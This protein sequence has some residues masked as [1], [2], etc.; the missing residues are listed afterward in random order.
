MRF[1]FLTS[2]L[3]VACTSLPAQ[4]FYIEAVDSIVG[5]TGSAYTNRTPHDANV[6]QPFVDERSRGFVTFANQP[7]AY[8]HVDVNTFD[9]SR[10]LGAYMNYSFNVRGPVNSGQGLYVPLNFSGY[11]D[12]SSE[13]FAGLA[14]V[15][16]QLRGWPST[17][18]IEPAGLEVQIRCQG[19]S[20][21]QTSTDLFGQGSWDSSINA[22]FGTI[23]NPAV[24]MTSTRGVISGTFMVPIDEY[25]WGS[26][27]VDLMAT[28]AAYGVTVYDYPSVT[29]SS[30]H[31]WAFIDP[32]FEI[33][34]AYL[35]LNPEASVEIYQGV[36]NE[37]VPMPIPE[38][39]SVL[40]M[41]AGLL[42]MAVTARRTAS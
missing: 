6:T 26:G 27:T 7:A 2:A 29:Q 24:G 5:F 30:G 22:S 28:A 31:S 8:V 19:G 41:L 18:S 42:G 32:K 15:R 21:C 33:A 4:A 39:G 40:M 10:A 37:S 14:H 17:G 9:A 13:S 12:L 25:G 35:A 34:S 11:V 38:P 23:A 16:L 3:L 1:R 36:G 20:T